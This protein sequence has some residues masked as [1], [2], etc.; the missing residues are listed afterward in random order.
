MTDPRPAPELRPA[1]F[2]PVVFRP[3]VTSVLATLALIALAV[4]AEARPPLSAS[5]WLSGSVQEPPS[6]SGWRPGDA[7][8]RN[9]ARKPSDLA[10]TGSVEPVGVRRLG[11]ANS[12]AT[13]TVSPAPRA[14]PPICGATAMRPCWRG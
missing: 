10:R 4:G 9:A 14:C 7:G 12:D 1:V 2:R 11:Q 13:G 8:P 6:Q 5:D 3:V